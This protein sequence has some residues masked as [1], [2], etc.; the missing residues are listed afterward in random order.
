MLW[1]IAGL[2][3]PQSNS[4]SRYAVCRWFNQLN[5]GLKK[6]PFTLE[7]VSTRSPPYR[8]ARSCKNKHCDIP[9]SGGLLLLKLDK[10]V[11]GSNHKITSPKHLV[12]L[13]EK[14]ITEKHAELGNRWAAIAKFLPGRTDNAIKNYWYAAQPC[15]IL[16]MLMLTR[17]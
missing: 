15:P 8:L 4:P 14:I 16:L 5:P 9:N 13:Q 1:Q 2:S 7:E 11:V 17:Q 12:Q 3:R 6:D 10:A